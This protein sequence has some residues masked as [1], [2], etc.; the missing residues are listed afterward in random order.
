ME[1]EKEIRLLAN[2]IRDKVIKF[3]NDNKGN[4][5]IFYER[6][7]LK[8]NNGK[9]IIYSFDKETVSITKKM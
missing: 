5:D 7:F 6:A 8:L 9:Q 3:V 2:E 4:D 1:F